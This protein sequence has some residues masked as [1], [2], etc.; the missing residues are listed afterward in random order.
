MSTKEKII[1]TI[2]SGSDEEINNVFNQSFVEDDYDTMLLIGTRVVKSCQTL[3]NKEYYKIFLRKSMSQIKCFVVKYINIT[4]DYPYSDT[5]YELSKSDRNDMLMWFS[6]LN[7]KMCYSRCVHEISFINHKNFIEKVHKTYCLNI[8]H[9][10]D[11]NAIEII[12]YLDSVKKIKIDIEMIFI[13]CQ[14]NYD[15][16]F[17][18]YSDRIITCLRNTNYD[19]KAELLL[20]CV[21]K[22]NFTM[23]KK[24]FEMSNLENYQLLDH[25][26]LLSVTGPLYDDDEEE[27][28]YDYSDIP[29]CCYLFEKIFERLIDLEFF[30][31]IYTKFK[32]NPIFSNCLYQ[33]FVEE[34]QIL[35]YQQNFENID[36]DYSTNIVNYLCENR[37]NVILTNLEHLFNKSIQAGNY[38]IANIFFLYFKEESNKIV[39]TKKSLE[40]LVIYPEMNHILFYFMSCKVIQFDDYI[41]RIACFYGMKDVIRFL[42]KECDVVVNPYYTI[43]MNGKINSVYKNTTTQKLLQSYMS[44]QYFYIGENYVVIDIALLEDFY[45]KNFLQI[46]NCDDFKIFNEIYL[47]LM[48]M[49]LPKDDV[50]N[51]YFEEYKCIKRTSKK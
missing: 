32:N 14:E 42:C 10:F 27:Y 31:Y 43:E 44:S 36:D 38:C 7:K 4:Q 37:D 51:E 33:T 24:L 12:D 29:F 2:N 50:F 34:N 18:K 28:H 3:Y 5:L 49:G 30:S 13:L 1:Q 21:G 16:L 45:D 48:T 11:Q 35:L 20:L 40:H 9:L 39:F 6:E 19:N 47:V 41:F 23:F 46:N 8:Q 26:E 17:D 15:V 22:N 25:R